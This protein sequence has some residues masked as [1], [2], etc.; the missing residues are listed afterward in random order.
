MPDEDKVQNDPFP[1]EDTGPIAEVVQDNSVDYGDG[2]KD[3]SE[4][5]QEAEDDGD[6]ASEEEEAMLAAFLQ[7]IMGKTQSARISE[8]KDGSIRLHRHTKADYIAMASG[9]YDN[10]TMAAGLVNGL[11]A[12]LIGTTEMSEDGRQGFK[13]LFTNLQPGDMVQFDTSE[14][15]E[16]MIFPNGPAAI[17]ADQLTDANAEN[18]KAG[19]DGDVTKVGENEY[20]STLDNQSSVGENSEAATGE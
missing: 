5:T 19:Q 18:Y 8:P 2:F 15:P 17:T 4:D 1:V 12:A 11:P 3:V 20:K 6:D 9:Q 14:K 13:A 7:K 16:P 10:F